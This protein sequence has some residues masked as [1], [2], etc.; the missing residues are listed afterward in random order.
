[1]KLYELLPECHQHPLKETELARF[2]SVSSAVQPGDVFIALPGTH[3][4][5]LAFVD[6]ALARGAC[7]VLTPSLASYP[8]HSKIIEVDGLNE[9]LSSLM[10]RLYGLELDSWPAVAITGTNGKTSCCH[11]IASGLRSQQHRVGTIG[12]LGWGIKAFLSQQVIPR[13]ILFLCMAL[14]NLC[15]SPL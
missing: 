15:S 3:Q 12:T 10:V 6:E 13:Q 7:L 5:G 11:F 2:Q 4:H 14:F 1:M 9:R 8:A